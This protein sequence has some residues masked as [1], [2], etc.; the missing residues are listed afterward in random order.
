M[1]S[2]QELL[3]LVTDKNVE[4]Q[5]LIPEIHLL[6]INLLDLCRECRECFQKL[7]ID[8]NYRVIIVSG[9]GRLFTAG[10]KNL[11]KQMQIQDF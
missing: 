5:T 10:E 6:Q 9:A 7:A 3:P 11:K 2:L 8:K 1:F 4:I